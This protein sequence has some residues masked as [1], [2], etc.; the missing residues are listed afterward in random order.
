MHEGFPVGGVVLDPFAG[1]GT[2]LK[3]AR[4]NGRRAIGI[5]LSEKYVELAASRLRYGV[6]G[7]KQIIGGK[8]RDGRD[9]AQPS[10]LELIP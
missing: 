9:F 1:T 8:E 4:D 10:L 7:T 6:K 5:D 2:T 3:V